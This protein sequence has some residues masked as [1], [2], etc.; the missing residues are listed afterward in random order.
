MSRKKLGF[1]LLGF[2]VLSFVGIALV[3]CGGGEPTPLVK[4]SGAYSVEVG[5]TLTLSAST[6]NGTDASYT[7]ASSDTSVATVDDKG[8]VT[9]VK[10]GET[11]ITATGVGSKAVGEHGVVVLASTTS[12]KTPVVMVSGAHAVEV[13]KTLSLSAATQ[14]GTDK[15]YSWKSSD[16]AVATVDDKG[17]VTAVKAGETKITATGADTKA[18]GEHAVVVTAPAT[19]PGEAVVLVSGENTVLTG[20]TLKLTAKTVN[21]TDASY[22]WTSSDE[23]IATVDK[24]GTVSGLA[25]GKVTITAE[26]AD[27][28]KT[29]TFGV[30]VSETVPNFDAWRNSAHA[31]RSAEAFRHWD[32]DGKVP[33]SCAKCHTSPGFRDFIGDDGS[34]AGTVDKEHVTT[35][36][37]GCETCHNKTASTLASVTFPSG[38]KVDG[39]NASAICM[40]CHQ[41]RASTDSVNKTITDAALA[42]DDTVSDKLRFQNVHYYAAG[43]TILAGQVR[44]GYQYKDKV[45]DWRFR[46]VPG[47][48]SCIGCHDPHSLKVKIDTCKGCHS[49][50]NK[51]EDLKNIRMIASRGQD[52][53]GDGD[54][55]KGIYFEMEGLQKKLLTAIQAYAKEKSQKEICYDE[56]GRYPYFFVDTDKDGSCSDTEAVSSN[57]YKA[58]TPRLIRATYNYQVSRKDPGAFAHNAKYVIQLLFDSIQDLNTVITAK[59][60]MSKAVRNDVGHFNGAGEAARRW[61]NDE[62]VSASCSKCHSGSEGLQFYLTYGIGKPVKEPD[63]GLDCA[64]CHTSYGTKFDLVSVDSV[65]FPGGKVIEDKGNSSNLCAT[66]HSG[67]TGKADIDASI[68]AKRYRFL[69][70]HYLPAAATRQGTAAQVGYEYDGKTYAGPSTGHIGGD[71]CADCHMPKESNH[72]FKIADVFDNANGCVKCHKNEKKAE[73]IKGKARAGKDYDGDGDANETLKAELQGLVELLYKAMQAASGTD[74]LCYESHSYPY[75]FKDTNGNGKCEPA[76]ATRTNGFASWTPALMKAAHNYQFALKE[77][78]A[79]AHNFDYM[80]QLLYDSIADLGGDVSKLTRP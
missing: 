1:A 77:P 46:H 47:N 78:G 10:A 57:G 52:Y 13:G 2:A 32:K 80:A 12:E 43:A 20:Q 40:T 25:S 42:D 18:A 19:Q 67:R 5:K 21:G 79:Y 75:F 69:N 35:S 68:A 51:T 39:L 17:V 55:S 37:V 60:D 53:D 50:I 36:V 16:E 15:S 14:N 56:K 34:A 45:Y 29:G 6:E 58:F 41:G 59:V 72:T 26:G 24:D 65:T 23:A 9:A 54:T 74:K 44:G 11:K 73:E 49:N 66:C 62:A 38:V 4:I 27:S 76:E 30:I 8:V 48:D 64:T 71:K 33:T 3:S 61:D 70:V 63:N 28:K 31:K 22:T 7:W